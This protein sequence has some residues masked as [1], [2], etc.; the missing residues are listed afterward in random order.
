[1][2]TLR[3]ESIAKIVSIFPVSQHSMW[4]MKM[5]QKG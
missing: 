1:M 3:Q 2:Q 4:T 5:G